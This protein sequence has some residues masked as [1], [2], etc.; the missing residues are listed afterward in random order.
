MIPHENKFNRM[1][2][3]IDEIKD[4][5]MNNPPGPSIYYDIPDIK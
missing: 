1:G 4:V 5:Q 3:G 2:Q